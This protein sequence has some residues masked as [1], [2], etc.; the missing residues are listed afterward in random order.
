MK[1][2]EEYSP[3]MNFEDPYNATS[4]FSGSGEEE[5]SKIKIVQDRLES[6][7][8]DLDKI[9][10]KEELNDAENKR[11]EELEVRIQDLEEKEFELREKTK[12]QEVSREEP[13]DTIEMTRPEIE[14][15]MK[16]D[17]R[18]ETVELEGS[19]IKVIEEGDDFDRQETTEFIRSNIKDTVSEDQA[20]DESLNQDEKIKKA[21]EKARRKFKVV[22][23]SD[24]RNKN[25]DK[26]SGIKSDDEVEPSLLMAEILES[27]IV[28][29]DESNVNVIEIAKNESQLEKQIRRA[30]SLIAS[31]LR[32]FI[33]PFR[34]I[35]SKSNKNIGIQEKKM[36][37]E[38]LR[39]GGNSLIKVGENKIPSRVKSED[40]EGLNIGE[41]NRKIRNA[42]E[43]ALE[44]VLGNIVG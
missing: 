12:K 19:D 6:L 15:L 11:L 9:N 23:S 27:S 35:F 20:D 43:R 42:E 33:S 2:T 25:V 38:V 7:R 5:S 28:A 16:K 21:I 17:N 22:D 36:L 34:K 32:E 18:D 37:Q 4:K 40:N 3:D 39:L 29:E 44:R 41:I 8:K 24:E 14:A 26:S 1:R 10:E 30:T 31:K 13:S